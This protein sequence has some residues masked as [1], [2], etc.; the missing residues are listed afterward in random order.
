[1]EPPTEIGYSTDRFVK[2]WIDTAIKQVEQE[3]NILNPVKD[4]EIIRNRFNLKEEY[5]KQLRI[6][7]SNWEKGVY[8]NSDEFIK[9][10]FA[11]PGYNRDVWF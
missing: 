7:K 8:K 1:M 5:L 9:A 10:Y 4:W 11:I 6:V 3:L 2:K